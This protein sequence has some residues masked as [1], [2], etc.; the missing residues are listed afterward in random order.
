MKFTKSLHLC[1]TGV[2]LA[3]GIAGFALNICSTQ[4]EFDVRSWDW[5]L[6][7]TSIGGLLLLNL[8]AHPQIKE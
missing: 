2:S 6:A 1:L 4:F 5:L 3:L 8:W 7:S